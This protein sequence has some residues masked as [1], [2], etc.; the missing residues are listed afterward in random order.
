LKILFNNFA[1]K[2]IKITLNVSA[3]FVKN[4]RFFGKT[5]MGQNLRKPLGKY[6][7]MLP[8]LPS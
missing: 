3:K 2:W 4:D 5:T 7:L 1:T 8:F 6:V